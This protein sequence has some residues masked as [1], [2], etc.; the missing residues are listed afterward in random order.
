MNAFST[1]V[2]IDVPI[3]QAAMGG[4]TPP[5]LAAAVSNAGGLGTLALAWSSSDD[6]R[7]Q[8][9]E[10][11]ALTKRPFAIDLVLDRPQDER[12]HI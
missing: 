12:L 3:V 5:E 1:L 11:K 8:I 4:A 7:Q 2:G 6:I 10:T 9:R